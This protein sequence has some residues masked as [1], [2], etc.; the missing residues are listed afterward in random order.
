MSLRER[1]I[2]DLLHKEKSLLTRFIDQDEINPVI[3]YLKTNGIKD[4]EINEELL[5]AYTETYRMAFHK[6]YEKFLALA[7]KMIGEDYIDAPIDD[8][9]FVL[10]LAGLKTIGEPIVKL[11][12]YG[13]YLGNIKDFLNDP[14]ERVK[15]E[16]LAL[17]QFIIKK[18]SG[19]EVEELAKW[20][21]NN[22]LA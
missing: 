22:K 12:V 9:N 15:A 11:E 3:N 7:N 14:R 17:L 16:A 13:N 1:Y 20:I 4:G 2:Q 18:G 19:K 10:V 21:K 5:E 6:N 8:A